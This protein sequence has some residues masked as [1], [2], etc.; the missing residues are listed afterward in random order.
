MATPCTRSSPRP[1]RAV[2][3]LAGLLLALGGAAHGT[4]A[5]PK[6]KPAAPAPRVRT[7]PEALAATVGSVKGGIRDLSVSVVEVESGREV[8]GYLAD[9][10]RVLASNTKLFTTAA[11][12]DLL[13]PTFEFVTPLFARGHLEA[14]VW[15]GDLAVVGSGDPNISGRFYD[16]DAYAVFRQWAA[17]VRALG[18]TKVDGD[19]YLVTGLFEPLKVHPDWPR[20]QLARWYEAPVD[21]LSFSDNCVMVRIGPGKGPGSPGKV[22]LVPDLK[23]YRLVANVTTTESRKS[24]WLAIQREPESG[25]IRV[26]GKVWSRAKPFEEWVSVPDP[27]TYFGAALRDAFREEGIEVAG[28]SWP[29]ER[30]PDG[31]W[32]EVARHRSDLPGTLAVI[33]HRSQNFYAESL[34]KVLGVAGGGNGSWRDGVEAVQGFL[35]R[36]GLADGVRLADG[37]GMSRNNVASPRH[38]A[39]L[40]RHMYFHPRGATF[41]QSLPTSGGKEPAWR[42]RLAQP[43]YRGNVLA[44]TGTLSNVSTLSG[45][46]KGRSGKLYAFSILAN[47]TSVWRAKRAQ[48][49]I[50]RAVIDH[51]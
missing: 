15:K 43:P 22:E 6:R 41:V 40:L 35:A 32:R 4:A 9:Q 39:G 1:L 17:A 3:L 10:P 28:L 45:Y 51:G 26:S 19:L 27:V 24:H 44:K 42:H 37:S 14:G 12:V 34:L 50:V 11:A 25:E 18:A 38:L 21:A 2:L 30:L 13:D 48:D 36:A 16:G 47:N 29:V 23:L 49:S 5:A 7:L 31:E 8:Y 20:D 46:A 33:N